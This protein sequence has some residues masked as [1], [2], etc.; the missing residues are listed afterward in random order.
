M[1]H[2]F[3][4]ISGSAA[5]HMNNVIAPSA[6]CLLIL[7]AKGINPPEGTYQQAGCLSKKPSTTCD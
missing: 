1:F 3:C 5:D 2:S 7:E 4:F 6:R